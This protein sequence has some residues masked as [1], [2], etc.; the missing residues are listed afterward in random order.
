MAMAYGGKHRP[1]ETCFAWQQYI[2][3]EPT[4][5]FAMSPLANSAAPH[6][7]SSMRGLTTRCNPGGRYSEW[8]MDRIGGKSADRAGQYCDVGPRNS[9][10]RWSCRPGCSTP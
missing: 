1:M 10:G 7:R 6:G 9:P 5:P 3:I 8:L 2:T 4:R